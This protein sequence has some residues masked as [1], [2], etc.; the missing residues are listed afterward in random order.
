VTL[1]KHTIAIISLT[2]GEGYGAETVLEQLLRSWPNHFSKLIV[3]APHGSRI[4]SVSRSCELN[5]VA[6]EVKR[7]ALLLNARAVYCACKELKHVDLVHAWSARAFEFA[8]IWSMMRG[9]P[10]GGTLH[11]HPRASFHG[12]CR[13]FIMKCAANR[14]DA[15]VAVSH[16]VSAAI[17][18]NRYHVPVQIIHNGLLDCT[19][20]KS[21]ST[22]VRVGFLGMYAAWK[23]KEIIAD[24]IEEL[25]P[26]DEVEW[27][28]YGRPCPQAD[29]KLYRLAQQHPEHVKLRGACTA[30]KIY[31]EI[32]VLVHASTSFDPFPT[33]LIEAARA[34]I[35]SIASQLGGATE[36]VVDCE[37]G[38]L[39]DPSS[40]MA[41]LA[42]V[43]RLVAD[44]QLR[45]SMGAAARRRF[46]E[47]LQASA[48]ARGY[49]RFWMLLLEK[50]KK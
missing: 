35:P 33:V 24:W 11:D 36:I 48:M 15:L 4:L 14:L 23:G 21:L 2:Q 13:R 32:D 17:S 44:K 19:F 6:L 39:F 16:A 1:P 28:L 40:P 26:P 27:Y 7:D 31:S 45:L 38:F 8:A 12:R 10:C 30:N 50:D 47:H 42:A 46:E 9:I 22:K 34:G 29:G 18:A 5:H 37:T 43:K 3:L 41:G 20:P 49:Q 25:L